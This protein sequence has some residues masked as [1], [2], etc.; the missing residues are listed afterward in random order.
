MYQI[1]V[2]AVIKQ[3]EVKRKNEVYQ[4]LTLARRKLKFDQ[5]YGPQA[6]LLLCNVLKVFNI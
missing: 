5:N 3:Y 2:F 1:V 6:M 4:M